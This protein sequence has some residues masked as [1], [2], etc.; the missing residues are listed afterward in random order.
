MTTSP[1]QQDVK[2]HKLKS[3]HKSQHNTHPPKK[4]CHDKEKWTMAEEAAM[5]TTL[6]NRK[7]PGMGLRVASSPLFVHW[8]SSQ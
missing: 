8:W 3:L 7:P 5:V 2:G 1:C 6:P 4:K